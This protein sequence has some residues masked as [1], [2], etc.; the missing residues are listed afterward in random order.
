MKIEDSFVVAVPVAAAWAA[1]I[2]PT[3][4]AACV[5]GCGSIEI[6]GADKYR[7][8]VAV[9]MGPIKTTFRVV[10]EISEMVPHERVVSVTRGEEGTRASL[11][12]A[13]NVLALRAL[14]PSTTEIAYSSEV[15]LTGRLGKFGLGLMKK[16]AKDTG[17]AFA[18]AFRSR[19]EGPG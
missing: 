5:P 17:D 10:V 11:L 13:N 4:V 15:S 8:E 2:D 7:A 3:I 19:L 16:K 6:L 9:A 14:D 18:L 1:I 12:T